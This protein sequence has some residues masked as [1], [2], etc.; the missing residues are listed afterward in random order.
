MERVSGYDAFFL[1]LES[2][3]QPVNVC[4]LLELDTS[5]MPGGYQYERLVG[6]LDARV[7]AAPDFRLKLADSQLNPS[8]PVWVEDQDFRL[9]RH[10]HR[11]GLPRPG[12]RTELAEICGHIAALP[13]DR[14]RPLW[15][16]WVIEGYDEAESI[17]VM[18]KSHHAAVDGV[19][20]ADLLMQLCG[21]DSGVPVA[22]PVSG[23]PATGRIEMAAAGIADVVRRPWRLVTAIPD[24]ARTVVHTVQRAVSGEAM[25]PP[26]AAPATAFNAPFTSRRNIAFTQVNLADVKKVKEKFGITVNDVVVA[27][28]AGALRRFLLDR[29]ELPEHPLVATVPMST[30]NKADRPGR[31]HTM[32][33]FCRLATDIEDV[34]ERLE[35]ICGN[36]SHA[37]GHGNEMAPTLIQDWTEFLGR[38]ALNAVVRLARHIPLPERPIHNLVLSN[39]PGP[40]QPLYF[41]GCAIT[42]QY[43]FGPIV[44]G[45]GL[46]VTVMSL[47]GRLGIGVIS[48]PD[49][50]SDVW[51]LADEFPVAL[52]ELLQI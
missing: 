35:T 10:V 33:M 49:L 52:D 21:L 3:T 47:N 46:N 39:V 25:A 7:A 28:T 20:G 51:D 4:C 50:V 19:G 1:E 13:L 42:A 31:N 22:E 30:R 41:L 44:I 14:S 26:F 9:D 40:Q 11:I 34:A 48:C 18:M 29:D 6:A 37:K 17:A 2:A 45:A 12:G 8:N 23:P 27:M 38:S 16:M 32:W 15:E 36:I 43:P 5:A 24:T